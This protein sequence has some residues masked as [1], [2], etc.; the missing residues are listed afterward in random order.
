MSLTYSHCRTIVLGGLGVVLAVFT[1]VRFLSNLAQH[2]V[3]DQTM[4]AAL[5]LAVIGTVPYALIVTTILSVI[6]AT[7][8]WLARS[9][10]LSDSTEKE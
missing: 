2:L 9:V 5:G 6:G 3:H 10:L 8:M 7:L 4:T 1:A